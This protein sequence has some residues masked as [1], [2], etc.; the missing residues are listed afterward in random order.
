MK[1]GV[2]FMDGRAG[3]D[4]PW[5]NVKDWHWGDWLAFNT[6]QP[7][8]AGSVTKKDLIATACFHYSTDILS[9]TATI[10]G[11][12]DDARKYR[13]LAARIK[14]DFQIEDGTFI[15]EVVVPANTMA[16]V[17]FPIIFK[18]DR[19]KVDA[20]RLNRLHGPGKG[21]KPALGSD[22]LGRLA[23]AK[24]GNRNQRRLK[25]FSFCCLNSSSSRIP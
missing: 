13:E 7:D 5:N 11:K 8:Y 2:N 19:R 1:G 9:Q 25:S 17:V 6:D 21:E 23:A 24:S 22:G 15:Y 12:T 10:L 3:E 20:R 18:T 14:A 4:H 16:T